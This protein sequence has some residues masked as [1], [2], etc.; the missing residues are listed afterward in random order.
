[1]NN[2]TANNQLV[3]VLKD[4][5]KDLSQLL[6]KLQLA[7][8]IIVVVQNRQDYINSI[9]TTKPSF[10]ILD[11][12]LL[13]AD[14]WNIAREI[15]Q[16]PD[17]S[18]IP[19]VL[20]NSSPESVARVAR[21]EWQNV[22]CMSEISEPEQIVHL[23]NTRLSKLRQ[24]RKP[25]NRTVEKSNT[26]ISTIA[27]TNKGLENFA[28]IVS[29]DLQAPLQS[30]A[31]L[32][33]L[34]TNEYKQDLDPKVREYL[35]KIGSSSSKMQALFENLLAYSRAGKSQQTWIVVDLNQVVRQVMKNL[36][37]AI[38][39]SQAQIIVDELPK[40]LIDP[41]EIN[42]L[43]QNLVENAIKFSAR[44]PQIKISAIAREQQWL[45]C[46]SDRG[47]GI[48]PESRSEIFEPFKRLNDA[49]DYPGTG[50]GLAICQKIVERYDGTIRVESVVGKGS[51][52][53][54]TLPV[55]A[56]LQPSITKSNFA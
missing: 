50:M 15:K 21:L 31:M 29:Q 8:Y 27:E 5:R 40:V 53:Y 24:E 33:E 4:A 14:G 45:I 26:T 11:L 54:F 34:L 48:A 49:K 32:S 43:L 51:K 36:H 55:D 9:E 42:R 20:I 3:V 7:Q 16:N 38:A 44:N 2:E 1:M 23:I 39:A 28:S 46:I 37:S 13:D 6:N 19:M 17:T 47:I 10:I 52:F 25:T 12:L 22:S 30:L 18:F 56:C 41:T 35:E